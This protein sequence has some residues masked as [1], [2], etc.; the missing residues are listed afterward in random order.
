MPDLACFGKALTSG[1]P[2][3]ALVGR[4]EIMSAVARIFYHPTFKGEA[5]SFAAAAAAL[6]IYRSEDVPT[7]V[8]DFG[9]RLMLG[10][11]ELGARLG[12]AGRMVGLPFRMVYRFDE[13]DDARRTLLRTLLQQELLKSGVLSFRGFLLPSAAHGEPELDRTLSAY[14]LAL[15]RVRDVASRGYLEEALEIPPVV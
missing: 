7:R 6:R 12:V 10:V 4:R 13:P 8:A 15:R 11:D 1:M 9:R 14:E 5:Y 3:S 2:L